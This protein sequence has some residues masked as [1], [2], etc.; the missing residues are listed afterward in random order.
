[1]RIIAKKKNKGIQTLKI[2][3]TLDTL[4]GRHVMSKQATPIVIE[5]TNETTVDDRSRRKSKK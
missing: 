5:V 3:P 4:T 2:F 1:M